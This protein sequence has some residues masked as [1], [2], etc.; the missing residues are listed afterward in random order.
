MTGEHTPKTPHRM[1]ARQRGWAT[2]ELGKA[3]LGEDLAADE[4]A[5]KSPAGHRGAAAVGGWRGSRLAGGKG[6]VA[7]SGRMRV[8]LLDAVLGERDSRWR[9]YSL[10]VIRK[11]RERGRT[12]GS[13][14][15]W[16]RQCRPERRDGETPLVWAAA[17]CR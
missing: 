17:L 15:G 11:T 2:E 4:A 1:A 10:S 7:L 5:F 9:F 12:H 16:T 13:S 3:A 8:C 6:R 14:R